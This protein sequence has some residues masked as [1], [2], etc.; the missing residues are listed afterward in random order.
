[1]TAEVSQQ[2]PGGAP[3]LSTDHR[4][5]WLLAL[6]VAGV[7]LFFAKDKQVFAEASLDLKLSRQQIADIS[8]EFVR[9]NGY[10]KENPIVSTVFN[11]D[12]QAKTFLEFELGEER[13][14]ELMK[15]AL[16]IW[17]WQTRFCKPLEREE[18]S[19]ALNP[20]GKLVSFWHTLENDRQLPNVSH[21]EAERM[22]RDFVQNKGAVSLQGYKVVADSSRNMPKRIDHSFTW[23]ERSQ[24]FN[25]ARMR[26]STKVSGNEIT[27]FNKYLYV[28]E[29]W[30]RRFS[31][32]RSWNNLLEQIAYVPFTLLY[33]AAVFIFLWALTSHR[34]RW[35]FCLTVGGV[36]GVL[37]G[38]QSLNNYVNIIDNYA[39][40]TSFSNYIA[41]AV[42]MAIVSCLGMTLLVGAFVAAAEALYR[43]D[44]PHKVA[45]EN[46]F[47]PAALRN[48]QVANALIVGFLSCGIAMGWVVFYYLA[49][50]KFGFW[51]PM[52]VGNY[53]ILSS[54]CPFFS[55]IMLGIQAAGM[56]ELLYRIICLSLVRRLVKNFWLANFIQAA[57]WGFMH[58]TYPQQPCYARG[59][60]LTLAGM[61]DGWVFN[62]FG[63]LAVF[64]SHYLFDAFLDAKALFGSPNPLIWFSGLL[65]LLPPFIAMVIAVRNLLRGNAAELDSDALENRNVAVTARVHEK[66]NEPVEKFEYKPLALRSRI[67]LVL[68]VAASL[69]FGF[70]A[71]QKP[72]VGQGMRVSISRQQAIATAKVILK[73]HH[74]PDDGWMVSA[75]LTDYAGG[76]ALQY[77]FEKVGLSKTMEFATIAQPGHGYLWNVRFFKPMQQDEYKVQLDGAGNE[78]SFN[79]T[80]AEDDP[81]GTLSEADA[82]KVAEEWL[83]RTHPEFIPY[84][85][86]SAAKNEKKNRTD[87]TL[88][89][90]V[91]KFKVADADC[92]ITVDIVGKSLSEFDESWIL[93]DA[94][95]WERDKRT[96]KDEV[97]KWLRLAFSVCVGFFVIKWAIGLL[98]VGRLSWRGALLLAVPIALLSLVDSLNAWPLFFDGYDT[99][100]PIG[101]YITGEVIDYGKNAMQSLALFT[102]LG[103]LSFMCFRMFFPRNHI[104]GVLK[105]FFVGDDQQSIETRRNLWTDAVI[106]AYAM[107]ALQYFIDGVFYFCR[108]LTSPSVPQQAL[109]TMC[110]LGNMAFPSA[111]FFTEGIKQG[112]HEVLMV[113]I[114]A[115]LYARYFNRAWVYFCF[116][117]IQN[118][119]LESGA[120][121]WQD[122]VFSVANGF[123]GAMLYW[124]LIVK[125][126][127][128]NLLAYF[129]FGA[130]AVVFNRMPK[131]ILHGYPLFSIE[132]ITACVLLAL[133]VLYVLYLN[134]S[135]KSVPGVDESLEDPSTGQS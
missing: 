112:V 8:R 51:S 118:A 32:I 134:V 61:F 103:I 75:N 47:K 86:A 100:K 95:K 99:T 10:D 119:V 1:M 88:T 111:D 21:E 50:K 87:Y 74:V 133:P 19:V 72:E 56:E 16:P 73:Q 7:I 52:D 45:I 106:A 53:E 131:I 121:Y 114:M 129:L 38:I 102:F 90:K 123:V 18:I 65:P 89:Y 122:Y 34:I 3:L 46:Y 101:S 54:V 12:D 39:T 78:V 20:Q 124:A 6:A 14:N 82:R 35:R 59:V 120:R 64:T 5:W 94:W 98:R 55:A 2:N 33:L 13:A 37:N 108:D 93:P 128:R 83:N 43:H 31:T 130:Y 92:E 22:A 116:A 28:P 69:A 117:F 110:T 76:S 36:Y 25:D 115:G 126:A 107:I 60:E 79:I 48:R 132:F 44:Y 58:S 49:G 81:G 23:E 91:P 125:I 27:Y 11:L 84:E 113:G 135:A 66:E 127:R 62:K 85:F 42:M 104:S 40:E 70:L 77:M 80:L 17:Y 57:A 26:V 71:R 105:P 24:D 96:T 29:A 68:A 30:E 67:L 97:L 41:G 4:I 15:A 9:Q 109:G 63:L